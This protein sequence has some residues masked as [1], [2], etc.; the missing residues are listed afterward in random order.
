MVRCRPLSM[1][2]HSMT[3]SSA[4]TPAPVSHDTGWWFPLPWKH[5]L[6]PASGLVGNLSQGY[7]SPSLPHSTLLPDWAIHRHQIKWQL[8]HSRTHHQQTNSFLT[9][10]CGAA[11]S[12]FCWGCL[13]ILSYAFAFFHC[14][15]YDLMPFGQNETWTWHITMLLSMQSTACSAHRFCL[16]IDK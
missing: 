11:I 6:L 10:C 15:V 16:P 7:S 1:Q 2:V 8:T 3:P 14:F 12:S 13:E 9:Q 4:E 5:F